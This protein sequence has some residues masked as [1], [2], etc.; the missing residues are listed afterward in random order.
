M[1]TCLKCEHCINILLNLFLKIWI[2]NILE[3][4]IIT[5]KN[6]KTI[7]FDVKYL[8]KGHKININFVRMILQYPH[9]KHTMLTSVNE[10][11]WVTLTPL[12]DCLLGVHFKIFLEYFK[13]KFFKKSLKL[14]KSSHSCVMVYIKKLLK[15]CYCQNMQYLHSWLPLIDIKGLRMI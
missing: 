13:Q 11:S 7:K 15:I 12:G 8:H 10:I 2:W 5:L 1:F 4:C 6:F 3:C 14:K 9:L